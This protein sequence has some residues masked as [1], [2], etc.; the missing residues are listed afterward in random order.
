MYILR[1]GHLDVKGML[2][3]VGEEALLRHALYICEQGIEKTKALPKVRLVDDAI[4]H[5]S[6]VQ[7]CG[8]V[9]LHCCVTIV[10]WIQQMLLK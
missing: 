10:K 8:F 3:A 6:L 7:Y 2:R 5:Q 9:V 1:L 4:M